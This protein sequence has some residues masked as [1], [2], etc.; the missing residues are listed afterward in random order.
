MK[1]LLLAVIAFPVLFASTPSLA[2]QID[3]QNKSD[4]Y[5]EDALV[6]NLETMTGEYFDNDT[7]RSLVCRSSQDLKAIVCNETG[8]ENSL[9][10]QINRDGSAVVN[11]SEDQRVDFQCP[12]VAPR[13]I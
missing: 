5:Q 4:L 10:T 7:W 1:I 12:A 11:Y 3:C 8:E 6:L 2:S 13:P 9:R